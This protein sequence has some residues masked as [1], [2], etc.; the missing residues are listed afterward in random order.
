MNTLSTPVEIADPMN[1][2]ILAISEDKIQ[3]F[4]TDPLGEIARLSGVD[5]P[6]VRERLGTA[7]AA[8]SIDV[9]C[10]SQ[11]EIGPRLTIGE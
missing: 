3:G 5:E 4:Q 9:I 1:T 6:T 11:R 7:G 10:A 2:R 8:T